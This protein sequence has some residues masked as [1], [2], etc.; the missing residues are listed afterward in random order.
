MKLKAVLAIENI[1]FKIKF[2]PYKDSQVRGKENSFSQTL[3]VVTSCRKLR[4]LKDK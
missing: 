3:S 2:Y 1:Y 4:D